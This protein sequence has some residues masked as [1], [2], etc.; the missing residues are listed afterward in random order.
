MRGGRLGTGRIWTAVFLAAALLYTTTSTRVEQ[1]VD[2]GEQQY[3]IVTGQLDNPFG[4]ALVHP[5]QWWIGRLAIQMLPGIEPAWAITL[6]V[7][8][9][10]AA[11]AVA[12][13]AAILWLLTR[14]CAATLVPVL[15]MALSHTFWQHAT[16]TETYALV[17]ALLTTEWLALTLLVRSDQPAWLVLVALANGLGVAN[18]ML[19]ALAMPVNFAVGIWLIRRRR[20]PAAMPTLAAAA[21][22]LGVSPLAWL[23]VVRIAHGA[24]VLETLHSAVFGNFRAAVLNTHVTARSLLL[25]AGYVVY[26]FP[27][28]TLPLAGYGIVRGRLPQA[29]KRIFI[30]EL[31]IY[32]LFALRYNVPDQYTFFFPAYL[33]LALFAGAGLGRLLCRRRSV[34][35]RRWLVLAATITALWNPLLYASACHLARS[36]GWLAAMAG[37]KPCRDGWRTYLLPWGIG[38]AHARCL[39]H[40]I[41]SLVPTEGLVLFADEMMEFGALYGRAVGRISPQVE[42]MRIAGPRSVRDCE[43]VRAAIRRYLSRHQPVVLVPRDRDRPRLPCLPEAIWQR[44][45]DLYVLIGPASAAT[46]DR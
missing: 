12:N 42:F 39:N 15:A 21:W 30:I 33:L 19:A 10:P 26:N 31:L 20:C 46:D 27:N 23:I 5:V 17:A 41:A 2:G 43:L 32:A 37:N 7:S 13:L 8:S 35:P 1:W 9:L 4:L 14:R 44:E 38:D 36:R 25:C 16:H 11:V 29:L 40:R 45:G 24:G 34:G 18:H 6:V 3:R 22:L 28:L